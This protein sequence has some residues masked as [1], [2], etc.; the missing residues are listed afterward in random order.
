[1]ADQLSGVVHH[2]HRGRNRGEVG[3]RLGCRG[4][5]HVHIDD[6][7]LYGCSP[8]ELAEPI[9]QHTKRQAVEDVPNLV[10]IPLP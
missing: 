7:H 10:R 2:L 5:G 3:E 4:R 8:T 9:P 6:F 1:M